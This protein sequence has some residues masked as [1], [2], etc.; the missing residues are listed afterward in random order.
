MVT[1]PSA[2]ARWRRRSRR[3]CSDVDGGAV[4]ELALSLGKPTLE[5]R[6]RG[7]SPRSRPPAHDGCGELVLVLKQRGVVLGPPADGSGQRTVS[8]RRAG[9]NCRTRRD[10]LSTG[11][12]HLGDG[13]SG[14]RYRLPSTTVKSCSWPIPSSSLARAGNRGGAT[15]RSA[16][17]RPHAPALRHG[18]DAREHTTRSPPGTWLLGQPSISSFPRPPGSAAASWSRRRGSGRRREDA[19]PSFLTN[20]PRPLRRPGVRG[21]C[22]S[23]ARRRRLVLG[24]AAGCRQ[25]Y[26]RRFRRFHSSVIVR[27]ELML[28]WSRVLD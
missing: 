26:G 24:C 18:P 14:S 9:S 10:R 25:A 22:S 11:Q 5:R 1:R 2:R 15:V 19:G 28:R 3:S 23:R 20:P 17:R 16:A 7:C 13:L 21:R 27:A 8:L 4:R 12:V 6:S